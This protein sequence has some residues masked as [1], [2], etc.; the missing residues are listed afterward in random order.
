MILDTDK[1]I[2]EIEKR[3]ELWD[4][5]STNYYANKIIK[6][7]SWIDECRIF[8]EK[9]DEM[10]TVQLYGLYNVTSSCNAETLQ[11]PD[12]AILRGY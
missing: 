7:N 10:R 5:S 11:W 9:Y 1:F 12:I 4:I 3:K 8:C 2:I 6:Q